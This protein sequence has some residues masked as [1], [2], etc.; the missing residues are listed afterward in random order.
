MESM[1]GMVPFNSADEYDALTRWKAFYRWRPGE[2]R[3]IKRRYR[4]RERRWLKQ[5]LLQAVEDTSEFQ[6]A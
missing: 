5:D 3:A 4:R 6:A 1:N 2:R